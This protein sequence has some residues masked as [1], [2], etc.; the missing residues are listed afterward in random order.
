MKFKLSRQKTTP[1]LINLICREMRKQKIS[2][3]RASKNHLKE[4]SE[5]SEIIEK[6]GLPDYLVRKKLPDGL[7]YGLFLHPK[8]KPILKGQL[9]APYAGDISLTA[10]NDDEDLDYAFAPLENVCLT[11]KEHTLLD[12]ARKWHP[13]R[14]YLLNVDALKNGNFTRYINHSEKPNV[15]ADI[16]RIPVNPYGVIP[17]PLEIFYFAKKAIQPGEQLLVSYEDGEKSYWSALNITPVPVTPKTFQLNSSLKII[18][19]IH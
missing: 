5:I 19:S 6:N 13:R 1:E 7:G 11:K 9:I 12:P 10:K 4:I 8:A 15:I 14:L 2:L 3:S 17:S 16:L 18:R